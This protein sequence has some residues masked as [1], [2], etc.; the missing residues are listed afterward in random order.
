MIHQSTIVDYLF[1]LI[2]QFIPKNFSNFVYL[3]NSNTKL[4]KKLSIFSIQITYESTKVNCTSFFPP[5][6]Q[7]P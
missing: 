5:I 2:V 4:I 7:V 1:L 3:V 6:V